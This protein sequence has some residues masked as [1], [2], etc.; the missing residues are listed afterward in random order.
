[1][2]DRSYARLRRFPAVARLTIGNFTRVLAGSRHDA[3]RFLGLGLPPERLEVTGN[4]KLD[5]QKLALT[6][7][8]GNSRPLPGQVATSRQAS[9]QQPKPKA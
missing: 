6:A 9:G 1:M 5:G 8:Q 7:K 3:K 4:L 2:S